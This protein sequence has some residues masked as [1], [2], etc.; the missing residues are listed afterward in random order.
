[1][2][3]DL[4]THH[5]VLDG[6]AALLVPPT[7]EGLAAGICATLDDP[8]A[9]ARRAAR[10]RRLVSTRHNY[11]TFKRELLAAYAAILGASWPAPGTKNG[12]CA[13]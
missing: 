3:T 7:S 6:A 5:Q 12:P 1:V 10:A 2:A 13:A 8:A 4:P 11:A 9:A